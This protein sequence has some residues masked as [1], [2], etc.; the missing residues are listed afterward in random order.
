M[1]EHGHGHGVDPDGEITPALDRDGQRAGCIVE[2][3]SQSLDL[4]QHNGRHLKTAT[5]GR[6]DDGQLSLIHI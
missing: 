2:T 3:A 6:F 4:R 5:A 1:P